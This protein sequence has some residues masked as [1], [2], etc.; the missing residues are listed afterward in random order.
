MNE[1]D[2]LKMVDLFNVV[3]GYELIEIFEEVDVLFLNICL[4]CEKV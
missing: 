1:Y 3:N 4:I 2:L